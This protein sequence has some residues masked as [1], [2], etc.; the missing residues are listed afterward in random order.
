M[1]TRITY[2]DVYDLREQLREKLAKVSLRVAEPSSAYNALKALYRAD[3]EA[4]FVVTLDG[5]H[6]IIHVTEVTRGL[7][8]K[9][10]V[11]PRE[12]FK[13][14]ILDSATAVIIAHNHPSGSLKP[15]PEDEDIT[16]RLRDA[17]QLLGIPVLDHLIF[18]ETS[19]IS[20]V[21]I[22]FAF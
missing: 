13:P 19:Y 17:G 10:I 8:N 15:S 1:Q 21:E 20:M 9:T 2:T 16:T 6:N 5:S 11:H 4:F 7:V 12:V 14:A 18:S 22:G 3:Q